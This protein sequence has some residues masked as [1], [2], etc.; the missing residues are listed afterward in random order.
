ML[1]KW[2][3]NRDASSLAASLRRRRFALFEQLLARVPSP[4][5]I[6]DVGGTP[7]FW[8]VIGYSRPG[9]SITLLNQTS[10]L[11]TLVAGPLSTGQT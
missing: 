7:D 11:S 2:A 1:K 6:L 3:D 8:R 4:V 5:R 10:R 9:V